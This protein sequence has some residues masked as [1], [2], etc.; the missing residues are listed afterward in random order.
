MEVFRK[1]KVISLTAF[2][3]QQEARKRA[4]IA[5]VQQKARGLVEIAQ[6]RMEGLS[7]DA[8]ASRTEAREDIQFLTW[9]AGK[10][11]R[12][13]PQAPVDFRRTVTDYGCDPED[14]ASQRSS[15]LP[16]VPEADQEEADYHRRIGA[17]SPLLRRLEGAGVRVKTGI[18]RVFSKD[19]F[20]EE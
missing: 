7:D 20:E 1:R 17:L 11:A 9:F 13:R 16:Y 10:I 6:K 2:R 3:E 19:E 15:G 4:E 5:V 18:K 12:A 8:F 14:E